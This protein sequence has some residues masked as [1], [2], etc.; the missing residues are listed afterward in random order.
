M[1]RFDLRYQHAGSI[2]YD[3]KEPF[4]PTGAAS[5]TLYKP[6]GSSHQSAASVEIDSVNTTIN[7]AASAGDSSIALTS[8]TGVEVGRAYVIGSGSGIYEW[9]K[10]ASVDGATVTIEEPLEYAYSDGATF[11]G[12]RLSYSLSSSLN[13]TLGNGYQAVW[14]YTVDSTERSVSTMYD[15]VRTPWPSSILTPWRYKEIVGD[16][17][18]DIRQRVELQG[19]DFRLEI[20]VATQ[21]VRADLQSRDLDVSLFKSFEHFDFPIAKRVILD[22]AFAGYVPEVWR[23]DPE[24]WIELCQQQYSRALQTAINATES[25]DL[26]DDGGVTEHE[27]KRRHTIGLSR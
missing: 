7:G 27:A 8:A 5:V 4:R 25:Y 9:V 14:V 22:F 3:V 20:E 12:N 13:D 24:R 26:D 19:Q 18:A 11:V 1:Y 6:G 10:V 16:L 23:D 15:V 21:A 2:F 17:G